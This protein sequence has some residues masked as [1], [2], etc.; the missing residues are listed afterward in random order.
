MAEMKRQR[1]SL[2]LYVDSEREG[3]PR[4]RDARE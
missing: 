3:E 2:E 4:A 1:D